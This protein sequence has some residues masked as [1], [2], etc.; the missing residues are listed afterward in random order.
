MMMT[1]SE[2]YDS[3]TNQIILQSYCYDTS[4]HKGLKKIH[5]NSNF[6]ISLMANLQK[7]LN[8]G[9]YYIF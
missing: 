2:G 8:S 5:W 6:Y 3:A 1:F 4:Y 7:N 9:R